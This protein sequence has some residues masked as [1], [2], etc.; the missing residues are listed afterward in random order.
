MLSPTSALRQAHSHCDIAPPARFW[1]SF[2]HEF[3]SSG[4]CQRAR[5]L[6]ARKAISYHWAHQHRPQPMQHGPCGLVRADFQYALHTQ[7]RDAVFGCREKPAGCEP[8]RQRRARPIKDRTRRHRR[9]VAACRAHEATVPQTP[10][11]VAAFRANEP[12]GPSQPLKIVQAVHIRSEPRLK[13]A[14]GTRVVFAGTRGLHSPTIP[15]LR[16]N[17]YPL[18]RYWEFGNWDSSSSSSL[19]TPSMYFGNHRGP[20]T[21]AMSWIHPCPQHNPL[22]PTALVSPEG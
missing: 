22:Q 6:T 1:Y 7:S 17:G 8:Y 12:L 11:R 15:R 14:Y 5:A 18:G 16:L 4:R 3:V 10:A 19:S 13:L 2:R 21:N 9:S 20:A